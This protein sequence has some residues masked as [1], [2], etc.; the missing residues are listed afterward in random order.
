MHLRVIRIR[1]STAGENMGSRIRCQTINYISAWKGKIREDLRVDFPREEER[2]NG[3]VK[4]FQPLD[5]KG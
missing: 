5:G 2:V 3:Y 1:L 4:I